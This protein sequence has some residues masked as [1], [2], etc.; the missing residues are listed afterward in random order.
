[1]DDTVGF[2]DV[3]GL[4]VQH[5]Y[6]AAIIILLIA[7]VVFV[8]WYRRKSTKKQLT[9][10]RSLNAIILSKGEERKEIVPLWDIENSDFITTR[11]LDGKLVVLLEETGNA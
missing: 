10:T 4:V 2:G 5:W 6:I 9:Q 3:L 11:I 7:T 1:M 8:I